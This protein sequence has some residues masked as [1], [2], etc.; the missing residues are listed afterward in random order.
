[1]QLASG[2]FVPGRQPHGRIKRVGLRATGGGATRIARAGEED[3]AGVGAAVER[4]SRVTDA[5]FGGEAFQ[6]FMGCHC[7]RSRAEDED[8]AGAAELDLME[9]PFGGDQLMVWDFRK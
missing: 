3:A 2:K 9:P 4:Q 7:D 6:A 8:A 5:L 1:V